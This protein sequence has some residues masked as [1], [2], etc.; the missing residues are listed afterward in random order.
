MGSPLGPTLAN[1]FL[2]HSEKQWLSDCPQDFCPN[3]Y[4]RYIDD[5]F[6]TFNSHEQLKRFVEYMNTKHPHIKFTFEHEHSNSFSFL[7][8][9]MCRKNNKLT[10]SVY[11]KTTF[12]GSFTNFKIFILTIYKFGLVCSLLHHF[13]ALI[14]LSVMIN[15]IMKYMR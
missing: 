2:C 13:V 3:I 7:D 6:V 11:G 1:A 4:R 12:S 9:S 10:T 15:F 8:V 14:L 5:I